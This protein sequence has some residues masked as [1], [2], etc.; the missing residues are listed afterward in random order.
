MVLWQETIVFRFLP[1]TRITIVTEP[2]ASMN[3][4]EGSSVSPSSVLDNG[5][6]VSPGQVDISDPTHLCEPSVLP[7]IESPVAKLL[8]ET[9]ERLGSMTGP[10]STPHPN[11]HTPLVV[12]RTFLL[13]G[14]PGVGKTFAVRTAVDCAT[15]PVHLMTLQ[16]SEILSNGSHV[17][18]A[19]T[20]LLRHFERAARLS[21]GRKDDSATSPQGQVAMVFLDECEAL[22]SSD[23]VAAM[24][25]FLLDRV[26]TEWER[27]VVVAA[28]NRIDALPGWIRRPGRFDR[29]IPMAPPSRI[30]RMKILNSLISNNHGTFG[31]TRRGGLQKVAET[32]VG[33][34]AADLTALVRRATL[35]AIRQ[36]R[37]M[38]E[39]DLFEAMKAVGASV[40]HTI[41][42]P[43]QTSSVSY[44][45]SIMI[46]MNE[47][48]QTKPTKST[49][50]FGFC[51]H[52][53]VSTTHWSR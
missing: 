20:T 23:T 8:L 3:V 27:I 14:P 29:E 51:S 5:D 18:E 13:T 48:N 31:G 38:T 42:W 2:T 11:L 33:Y 53:T 47:P 24:L 44:P 1:S 36:T 28:T 41:R 7:N 52:H 45:R 26:E 16:G 49:T 10:S 30:E 17:S 15:L 4:S 39:D 25:A 21:Y 19:A 6:D 35:L 37:E 46:L 50:L 32:C 40:S 22:I 9:L 43:R 12:P 34:V